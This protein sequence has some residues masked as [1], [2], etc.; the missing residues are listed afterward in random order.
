MAEAEQNNATES[1][2][3]NRAEN[4]YQDEEDEKDDETRAAEEKAAK[5]AAKKRCYKFPDPPKVYT[6]VKV[7]IH[8]DFSCLHCRHANVSAYQSH[9]H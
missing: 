3:N 2:E 1:A 7:S 4:D 5:E 6:D 9:F 8:V